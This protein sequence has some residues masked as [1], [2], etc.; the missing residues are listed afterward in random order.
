MSF[1]IHSIQ[2]S[3]Q[4]VHDL[5]AAAQGL[6]EN[7]KARTAEN[8]HEILEGMHQL[9]FI[10]Q[11]VEDGKTEDPLAPADITQIGDYGMQ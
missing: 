5:T 8:P 3:I 4:L 7:K 9:L 6:F 10:V 1:Q 11:Q 2:E